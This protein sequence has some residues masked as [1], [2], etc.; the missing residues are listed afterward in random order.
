MRERL[1]KRVLSAVLSALMLL[2][3]PGFS[4][5][6][7]AAQVVRVPVGSM[8]AAGTSAAAAG[9]VRL[10]LGAPTLSV[11][12]AP[13]LLSAPAPFVA[14]APSAVAVAVRAAAVPVNAVA[15]PIRAAAVP[16][17]AAAPALSAVFAAA[18]SVP[19]AGPETPPS[20]EEESARAARSFDQAAPRP[21]DETVVPAGTP[22]GPTPNGLKP[23]RGK[24]PRPLWG[25]FWGH[26]ITTVLGINFHILSQPFLV[27]NT[28]GMGTAT[29]GFVR[30]IHMGSMAIVNFLPI[31]YLID[32]TDYRVVSIATAVVRA[33]LM[34][35]IPVLFGA[36][37]LHFW[38]LALIVALNP[39]FQS[40]MIVAEGA[41]NKTILGKDEALNKDATA[42]FSKWD[43]LAGM[44]MPLVAG[45]GVGALVTSF[46][47]G[48]YAMAYGVYA[49]LLLASIP[50]YWF[51]IRDPRFPA[52]DKLGPV[53]F[54]V[55]S[56]TFLSAL[57]ASMVHPFVGVL[58]W[59][60]ASFFPAERSAFPTPY[61][62]AG[63]ERVRKL[64]AAVRW[65]GREAL[66]SLAGAIVLLPALIKALFALPSALKAARA[67]SGLGTAGLADL[68]DRYKPMQGLAFIL[69]NKILR[70]LTGVMALEVLLAD[71]L[72]FVIIPNL[73]TEAV[74]K[75]PA[76][77]PGFLATAGG[78][79]G[80][81][82]SVEY[83]GRFIPS[84]RLEGEKGDAIIEKVGHGRFYKRAAIATLLFWG[85]LAP[86]YLTTGMFWVNLAIV[87]GVMFAVQYF[88]TPVG[89]V[90]APV[91]RAEMDDTMLARIESAMFM[92]DVA[93][94]S[95]GALGIGLMM[96][97]LGL[98]AALI[99]TCAFLSLTSILQYKV[100]S[101][102]YP[103]GNRPPKK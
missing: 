66:V 26:D 69:R 84:M 2:G 8:G 89:I 11:L 29:M 87:A 78:L 3:V 60:Y 31:G 42:T 56:V 35:S 27:Q 17:R 15:V 33:L 43:A 10:E 12:S 5:Y 88:N 38:V 95:V 37:L 51:M 47:L 76:Y 9:V 32:K 79:M 20:G 45:W 63:F 14:A 52:H 54:A 92:V 24:I 82:F 65:I 61:G 77:L 70:V 93:F 96:D 49:A 103:D 73:I 41:A 75:A 59:A 99:A 44:M 68:L 74:G 86:L 36:G 67:G 100:P 55:Q 34:G 83:L 97:F 30:N 85:L 16:A 23:S 53:E 101:W 4:A 80:V 28:L 72:P 58:R 7:A 39:L 21:A 57:F 25:F 90:L 64:G 98:K 13:A 102:I 22:S 46:G 91:K 6:E 71:A 19:A 40:T 1:P 81:L 62:G 18:A 48:G 94:E 50:V